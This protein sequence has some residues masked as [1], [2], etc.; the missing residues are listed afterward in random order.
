[1]SQLDHPMDKHSTIEYNEQ[2]DFGKKICGVLSG[3]SIRIIDCLK[4]IKSAISQ[5]GYK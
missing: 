2:Y 1:M 3:S 5:Q 4:S